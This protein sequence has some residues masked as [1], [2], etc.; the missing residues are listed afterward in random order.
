MENTVEDFIFRAVQQTRCPA[1]GQDAEDEAMSEENSCDSGVGMEDG[2][3]VKGEDD[4]SEATASG[5]E[6]DDELRAAFLEKTVEETRQEG[7]LRAAFLERTLEETRGVAAE[8]EA[9]VI[10]LYD[11]LEI[12][13]ARIR[14]LEAWINDK[15]GQIAAQNVVIGEMQAQISGQQ[16]LMAEMQAQIATRNAIIFDLQGQISDQKALINENQTQISGQETLIAEMHSQCD[17][18]RRE[19]D[20][21][22]DLMLRLEQGLQASQE[23]GLRAAEHLEAL[24]YSA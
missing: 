16:A 5:S 21:L 8:L 3:N 12:L 10:G 24:I 11:Q 7:E 15:Q 2:G 19:S 18:L 13:N 20:E 4:D 9:R 22:Q 23:S 14:T 6:G 1:A 17:F